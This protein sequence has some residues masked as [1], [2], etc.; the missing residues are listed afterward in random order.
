MI[1]F[2]DDSQMRSKKRL[3][4][5]SGNDRPGQHG[6]YIYHA[7]FPG[8]FFAMS[9]FFFGTGCYWVEKVSYKHLKFKYTLKLL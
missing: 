1:L 4:H 3:N 5:L 9:S 7:S 2:K 6:I 8:T